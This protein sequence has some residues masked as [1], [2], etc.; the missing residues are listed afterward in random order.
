MK[1]SAKNLIVSSNKI[2]K[3]ALKKNADDE[4]TLRNYEND[5]RV[6]ENYLNALEEVVLQAKE[7]L[8]K[9]KTKTVNQNGTKTK[10]NATYCSNEY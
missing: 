5:K 10:G 9:N 7:K 3:V 2:A 6:F 1:T 4:M 8:E